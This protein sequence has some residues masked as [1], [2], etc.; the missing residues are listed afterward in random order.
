M[1]IVYLYYYHSIYNDIMTTLYMLILSSAYIY[2]YL[3][4]TTLC[5]VIFFLDEFISN[6]LY[7]ILSAK[8]LTL[9]KEPVHCKT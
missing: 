3:N 6:H 2:L 9:L 5:M 7:H 8:L 4:M 1:A